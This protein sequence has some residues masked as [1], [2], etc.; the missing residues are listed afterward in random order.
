MDI[1]FIALITVIAIE[2][3]FYTSTLNIFQLL[4]GILKKS[5]RVV[6]SQRISDHW[7]ER[8]LIRYAYEIIKK[9]T[10]LLTNLFALLFLIFLVSM[11]IDW[12]VSQ[13]HKTMNTLS[14]PINLLLMTVMA[15]IYLLFIRV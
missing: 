5:L 2:Y 15:F 10:Y 8:V 1:I 13:D 4:Q 9:A 6:V 7:K 11:L 3:F 14:K 12:I